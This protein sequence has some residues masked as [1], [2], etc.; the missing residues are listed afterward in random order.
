M[1]RGL[2][3]VYEFMWEKNI[4]G[5]VQHL[6]VSIVVDNNL[7]LMVNNKYTTYRACD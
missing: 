4:N 2:I 7:V 1:D 6:C 3:R 5:P